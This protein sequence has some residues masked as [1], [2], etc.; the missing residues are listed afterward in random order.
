MEFQLLKKS[1]ANFFCIMY[2]PPQIRA[3]F[4]GKKKWV[5]Y[6]S[7]YGKKKNVREACADAQD[8]NGEA[9]V[10]DH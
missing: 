4:S 2:P 7:K 3:E 10:R 6:T 8:L 9:V 5:H 1:V